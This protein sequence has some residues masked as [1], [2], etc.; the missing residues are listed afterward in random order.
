MENLRG[1]KLD[2]F[3]LYDMMQRNE[4]RKL[5]HCILSKLAC[6]LLWSSMTDR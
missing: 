5:P 6:V 4:A 1:R 2:I 3:R